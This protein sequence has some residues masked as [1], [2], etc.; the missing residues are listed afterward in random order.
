[1]SGHWVCSKVFARYNQVFGLVV[2]G[3]QCTYLHENFLVPVE[4]VTDRNS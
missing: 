2:S 4:N 1:M 3:T